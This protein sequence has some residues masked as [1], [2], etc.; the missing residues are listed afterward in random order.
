MMRQ[1]LEMLVAKMRAEVKSCST[2]ILHEA[3]TAHWADEIE[4]LLCGES[5]HERCPEC[6][7]PLEHA[8][9]A[10]SAENGQTIKLRAAV[11]GN[12]KGEKVNDE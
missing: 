12:R 10:H 6:D 8:A 1:D 9:N 5:T 2:G 11:S 3:A 7:Q 4:K